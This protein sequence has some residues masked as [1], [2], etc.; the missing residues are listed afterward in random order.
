M[1]GSL[2]SVDELPPEA[3]ELVDAARDLVEAVLMTDVSPAERRAAVSEIAALALRLTAAQRPD[4]VWLVRVGE[5]NFEHLTQAGTGRLSPQALPL[6]WLTP[7]GQVSLV[8]VAAPQTH[9]VLARCTLRASHVGPPGRVHGGVV[10][11]LLDQVVGMAAAA[12]NKPGMTA[13]LDIR[14]RGA[15]PYGV[16]LRVQARYTHTEGRKHFATGEIL[17]DGVVTASALGVFIGH[18]QWS[19]SQ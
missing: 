8:P 1:A 14:Y 18:P 6:E 16:P 2:Q 10:A 11:T 17:A 13:G 5:D 7:D 15:T 3:F 9:E 12:V 19:E 4:P